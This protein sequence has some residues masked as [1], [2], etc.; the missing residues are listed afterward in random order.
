VTAT[1]FVLPTVDEEQG[2]LEQMLGFA[3]TPGTSDATLDSIASSICRHL[4]RIE[5]DRQRYKD[6]EEAE[7]ARITIF[8]ASRKEKLDHAIVRL[9]EMGAE[10]ARRATF[11]GKSKSRSVAFGSYGSRKVSEKIEVVDEKKAIDWLA[12]ID[13]ASALRSKLSI[14]KKEATK[15]ILA[16]LHATGEIPD[17]FN[18][19]EETELFFVKAD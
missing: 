13:D 15:L 8:Y 10:V 18:F 11:P 4:G 6:A 19:V 3:L 2:E 12:R 16:H 7:H 9:Q 17:G 1:A 5:A 14:D